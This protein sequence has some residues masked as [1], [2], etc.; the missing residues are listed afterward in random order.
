MLLQTDDC[1][2]TEI[3]RDHSDVAATK[4]GRLETLKQMFD[5]LQNAQNE[6]QTLQMKCD[7]NRGGLYE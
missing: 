5:D 6:E 2:P 7:A 4:P 3:F 1:E